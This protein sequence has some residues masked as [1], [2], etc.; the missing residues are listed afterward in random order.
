MK[1]IQVV[2]SALNE[3]KGLELFLRST[4]DILSEEKLYEWE[5]VIFDNGSKDETWQVI[6]DMALKDERIIG[7]RMSRTFDL[8][9]ALTAG[10][11]KSDAD[12]VILMT[13]DMQ[14][15]PDFIPSLLRE[16]EKGFDQVLVKIIK[17]EDRGFI[18]GRLTRVF[19]FLINKS[20]NG[21]IPNGVS[22]YRLI[23]RRVVEK[24]RLLREQNRFLRGLIAWT[25]YET[26]TLELIRPVRSYGVSKVTVFNIL[27]IAVRAILA[28]TSTLI[29]TISVLSLGVSILSGG[30]ILVLGVVWIQFGVPFNGYGTLMSLVLLVLCIQSLFQSVVMQY[31]GLIYN[32]SK[33]RPHYIIQDSTRGGY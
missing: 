23:S 14:D 6:C 10:L 29:S 16:W 9:N 32:E 28:H 4:I 19:Y 26:T 20:S 11:D 3:G 30:A 13:S 27:P 12:A 22:D 7:Y 15:P 1:K 18:M 25:G 24:V 8:D 5:I 31:I 2:S 21:L 17:R 33:Q